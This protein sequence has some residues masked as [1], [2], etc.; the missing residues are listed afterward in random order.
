M[1]LYRHVLVASLLLAA[2]PAAAEFPGRCGLRA[3][4]NLSAFTGEFGD[5]VGPD[6]R[7]AANVAFVYEY[8]FISWLALHTGVGYSGKGGVGHSEGTDP[9]GNPTGTSDDTW[10]FNYVEV[11]LLLR[12]RMPVFGTKHV[13]AELGPMLDFRL[14]GKFE[15]TLSGPEESLTDQMNVFDLGVGA[16]VGI[17]FPAGPGRLGLETRYTRGLDDLYDVSGTLST[18]N[19]AWT[20]AVSYTR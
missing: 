19:Q 2:A 17:E 16:G 20:F 9:V 15:S 10:S 7:V 3:G 6:N 8:D 1:R 12:G 5:L 4:V 18:I 14:S 11:P 13:F